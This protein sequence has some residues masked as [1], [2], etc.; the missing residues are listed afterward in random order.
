MSATPAA[1]PPRVVSKYGDL[2][3]DEKIM[4]DDIINALRI[5][6]NTDERP[7]EDTR[8]QFWAQVFKNNWTTAI[9]ALRPPELGPRNGKEFM[10]CVGTLSDDL[11]PSRTQVKQHKKT[12]YSSPP[13]AKP[14]RR[15]GGPVFLK[16][17]LNTETGTIVF[18]WLD[19]NSSTI[20]PAF[21][22]LLP[23]YTEATAKAAAVRNFDEK[24]I[25]RVGK[26][27]VRMAVFWARSKL[28][29]KLA[30]DMDNLVAAARPDGM[31]PDFRLL[32]KTRTCSQVLEDTRKAIEEVIRLAN[33]NPCPP[34]KLSSLGSSGELT[35][36]VHLDL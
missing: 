3:A 10:I 24:E 19:G 7:D 12:P 35:F 9:P 17:S 8:K 33:A 18:M 23:E 34:L 22:T 2:Q 16:P 32:R 26:W 28:C 4:A 15:R 6:N 29:R 30:L 14:Q 36:S 11:P 20:N 5:V 25:E 13:A 21:T 31:E 1:G 27:N